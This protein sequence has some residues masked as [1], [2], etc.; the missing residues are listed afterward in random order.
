MQRQAPN[1]RDTFFG[2]SPERWKIRGRRR[3]SGYPQRGSISPSCEPYRQA[4]LED[5]QRS[6]DR[7]SGQA[8]Q[9]RR[10]HRSIGCC[11]L[12]VQH[13]FGISPFARDRGSRNRWLLLKP[14]GGPTAAHES[15]DD[16]KSRHGLRA[17]AA[18]A[19]K[20]GVAMWFGV[21]WQP[22]SRWLALT[23]PV[24]DA[25]MLLLRR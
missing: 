9:A 3:G 15:G 11:N 6:H 13:N 24:V 21:Q 2:F 18:E 8:F 1:C 5:G 16:G 4:S 7:V 22:F 25:G 20:T 12:Q 23:Q 14:A 17:D 19:R 10:P